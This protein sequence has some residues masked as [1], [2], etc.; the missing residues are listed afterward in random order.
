MRK[1]EKQRRFQDRPWQ[2]SYLSSTARVDG[3]PT[4]ILEDFYIPVLSR[5]VTYDRVA[6]YFRST[7]L[8]A[9]SQGFSAFTQNSGKARLIVGADMDPEDVQAALQGTGCH[10]DNPLISDAM[11]QELL[12]YDTW[13]ESVQWGVHLLA[14][15]VAKG[16]LDIRVAFRV[17]SETGEILKPDAVDDGYVHMKFGIFHDAHGDG[18]Y[19]TG[20]LNESRTALT[21]NAENID[22][23]CTWKGEDNAE[24]LVQAHHQFD[25]LWNNHNPSIRVI[26]L[27]QAVEGR[28]IELS[29]KR[30]T[31]TE[32][33]GKSNIWNISPEI[34][35]NS[36]IRNI[37]S[38]INGDSHIRNASDEN[39]KNSHI[40]DVSTDINEKTDTTLTH[41]L[42][43]PSM[44]EMLTF[45]MLRDAPLLPGGRYVGMETSPIT[46]WPHQ[47]IVARRLIESW[48]YSYL[49]CD[50]VGLGKTIEAGLVIRSLWLSG[51][52]ERV[53]IA[54]P[55][56]LTTQWHRE[57]ADKFFLPF[58]KNRGG[59]KKGYELLWP[60]EKFEISESFFIPALNI[61]STGLVVRPPYNSEL[62]HS[63][64]FDIIL[65]DEAHYARRSNPTMGAES[66]A[67]YNKLFSAVSEIFKKKTRALYLATATPMQLDPVEV[68][69]LMGLIDRIG[70]FQKDPGLIEWYYQILERLVD[71]K[72][73]SEEE[74]DFLKKVMEDISHHDPFY[75]GF[76]Q[77]AVI[78]TRN[79]TAVRRWLERN[80]TPGRSDVRHLGR[81][82]F[83]ASPLNRIML[84]HTRPLLKIYRGKGELGAGLAERHILPIPE[85]RLNDLELTCYDNLDLYCDTLKKQMMEHGDNAQKTAMGF[86]LMFLRLRFAS[87]TYAIYKS[88]E[89]RKA[90]VEHTL[91]FYDA[92]QISNLEAFD[93][94]AWEE[95]E[96]NDTKIIQTLLKNRDVKDLMWEREY[97]E[98][99]LNQMKD[100]FGPS[101][102]MSYLLTILQDRRREN[103]R[104]RQTVVFTRFYDTLVDI[105]KR[106][107][108]V[109]PAM[110]VG[111]Y[112][113][114]GGQYSKEGEVALVGTSRE[115]IKHR[116][117]N[118]STDILI[119]TDAA[120]E[121]LNLQ[122]AD[123]LINFDLPWNPMKVEQ[124]IGRIDRIG[125]K[126]DRIYVL[127]LCY[128]GT[129]EEI[130]YG[131]LL[132]RLAK[133]EAVVGSQ[134][135]SM[136]HIEEDEFRQ[137]EENELSEEALEERIRQRFKQV[138][139]RA[140]S[141]EIPPDQLYDVY[142]EM[143]KRSRRKK[144]A[145]D[146]EKIW[147][148]LSTSPYLKAVGCRVKDPGRH[149]LEINHIPGIDDGTLLTTSRETFEYGIDS[150]ENSVKCSEPCVDEIEIR[151]GLLRTRLE[152]A[153]YG[154]PAF[155]VLME[156]I[157]QFD[158]SDAFKRIHIEK[159][160][161][162]GPMVG[163]AVACM[164]ETGENECRLITSFDELDR[165]QINEDG[166]LGNGDCHHLIKRLR[167]ICHREFETIYVANRI[168]TS[169][170]RSAISQ[171]ALNYLVI[172]AQLKVGIKVGHGKDNFYDEIN[173]LREVFSEKQTVTAHN[174]P[175]AS[176]R[177]LE[178]IFYKPKLPKVGDLISI[179]VPIA[180][181]RSALSQA[182]RVANGMHVKKSELQTERVLARFESD[183]NDVMKSL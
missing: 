146:L 166:H 73:L 43:R 181:F 62:R 32:I 149:I 141:R 124:R 119:C 138:R 79:K 169:N 92:Q 57:M 120:A 156:H 174:V 179:K 7:S 22:V 61:I 152:F 24:R 168:Q 115:D 9:A 13:P 90:K 18:I 180:L 96:E 44:K 116:F 112:S 173:R 4:D 128:F 87:S 49:M 34:N 130:V 102:K 142:V 160:D 30:N 35:E 51:I 137:L 162:S 42:P 118:G 121:G 39:S 40:W 164:N 67:R 81:L 100:V 83:A 64:P 3:S 33:N 135:F 10:W 134:A 20:S 103:D 53:L 167:G 55:A 143:S 176:I 106:L 177:K 117:L 47:E 65:L 139:I 5:S 97:I 71:K 94:D 25:D 172:V 6:G 153:T 19:M 105:V 58:A 171:R 41:H 69:D 75:Y 38:K 1:N 104:Y 98:T 36:H 123:L 45:A 91:S 147:T 125:Q 99:M 161:A 178:G 140:K 70:P 175:V 84:R 17:H 86:Y 74:W 122:T 132:Q 89:R 113:G 108:N 111:T 63:K 136:V 82:V 78:N 133:A 15:M 88:L 37:S 50:E 60:Q 158:K 95:E 14:W 182:I 163:Y 131:R 129:A 151:S 23:H 54:S 110:R 170:I 59:T 150:I 29:G 12:N 159:T 107:K 48:P 76:I 145:V 85:I 80:R 126:H 155:E 165:I 68:Y 21:L 127:N 77:E 2:I 11:V 52:A 93:I 148:I 56:G 109:D 154:V 183:L 31:P 66:E 27:P 101:S 26:S 28:L 114:K 157:S 8:A 144:T 46:P 72:L 16:F